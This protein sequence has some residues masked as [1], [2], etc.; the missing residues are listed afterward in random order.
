MGIDGEYVEALK[1]LD[2]PETTDRLQASALLFYKC[3][4]ATKI[5]KNR[6]F[7]R[8]GLSE[9]R[10]INQ[11]LRWDNGGSTKNITT[12]DK[13]KNPLIHFMWR[14]RRINVYVQ[15]PE[16]DTNIT[17]LVLPNNDDF[18]YS[19]QALVLKDVEEYFRKENLKD[20]KD[21]DITR[22]CNWFSEI[23][24]RFGAPEVFRQ[25]LQS[26]AQTLINLYK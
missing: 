20:Y 3:S 16:F 12:L 4:K 18:E 6:G 13:S 23:Q 26:Y 1:K 24:Y 21:E 10:S 15:N 19:Y 14:L 22:I 7:L 2:I 17:T 11:A 8:A 25:G 9:F 5:W